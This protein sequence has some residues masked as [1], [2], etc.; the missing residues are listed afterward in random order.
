MTLLNPFH[1]VVLPILLLLTF[2]HAHG[3]ARMAFTNE[4][5]NLAFL[6]KP[7]PNTLLP[8][9]VPIGFPVHAKYQITNPNPLTAINATIVSLPPHTSI[10]A[11]GCGSRFTL[12]PNASCTLTL[13]VSANG[14]RVGDVISGARAPNVL[15]ACWNDGVSCAGVTNANDLLRVNV[16]PP[17]SLA[18]QSLLEDKLINADLWGNQPEILSANYGFEGIEG[19]PGNESGVVAAGGAWM[20][21]TTPGAPFAAY[22]TAQTPTDVAFGFGYPTNHADAMPICFSWPVLPSTVRPTDFRLTLNT[23]EIVQPEVASITP[24]FLYNKRSCVVIFGKFGNRLSPGTPGAVYPTQVTIVDNGT[25]LKL[26]GPN[27]PVSAVGLSKSSGNPYQPGGGPKLIGAKLS[28]MN[29]V[30]QDAPV[31]F[32]SNLPNGGTALYG[33]DAEYRLRIYTTAGIS[34][35]GVSAILPTDFETFFQI[36]VVDG[37]VSQF[38]TQANI[39]YVFSAGIIQVVGLADLGKYDLPL[40]DAYVADRDNYLDI[41]LKGDEAAMRLITAVII[42]ATPP[43]L[44][45]YNPG[46]PGNNPTPGVTYTSP[47]PTWTQP[48][49]IAIDDPMTVT[50]P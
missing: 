19:V 12:A 48:V 28:I 37:G 39:P 7:Q 3:H 5:Q 1:R 8:R 40:N 46:G 15:M 23:G 25:T 33:P 10:N 22:T 49:T 35:D 6:I 44:P 34:P 31:A 2:I 43:Y 47:G 26:V 11:T 17:P 41:I 14:L 38:I 27:G 9:E 21:I 4:Q 30:G 32:Q 16:I 13:T 45:L 29:D 50:Y 24:N 18:Y 36:E 42:P 20:T